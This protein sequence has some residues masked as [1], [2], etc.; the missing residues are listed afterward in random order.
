MSTL[1]GM[2]TVKSSSQYTELALKS[3]FEHTKFRDTDQFVLID[4]D[5]DWVSNHHKN[6]F[7]KNNI[8]VNEQPKNTS[9][10]INTLLSIATEYKQDFIFLSNDVIFTPFWNS[11][12][13][14]NTLTIP[15]CNQTHNYGINDALDLAQFNYNYDMLNNIAIQHM[16]NNKTPYERLLMP[17]YV[18]CIPYLVYS[19]VGNFD[20]SFNVGGEDVDYRLRCLQKGIDVK[21]N[22]AFLLHFNG[23][24][25]WN[26]VETKEQT[27]IRDQNY[28]NKFIE[29]WGIDLYNLCIVNGNKELTIT[30]Y[31]LQEFIKN[32]KFNNAIKEV[33][34][35]V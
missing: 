6:A 31:S 22:N 35:Y 16:Q 25:S 19:A 8:I 27:K 29:K 14:P 32:N 9:G 11:R 12:F 24:S 5:G 10:N 2:I 3:F 4:N 17:T 20:E 13:I 30:K 15:S 21:Y 18:C 33:L 28:K 26:G 7:N 23:K 1:Y 34:K